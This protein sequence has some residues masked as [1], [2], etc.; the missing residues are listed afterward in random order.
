MA[1]E[2][3]LASGARRGVMVDAGPLDAGTEPFCRGIVNGERQVVPAEPDQQR[4][5]HEAEKACGDKGAAPS[6][7]PEQRI[8]AA[9]VNG[10]ASGT[11]PRGDRAT[12]L[13][14]ENSQK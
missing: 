4:L 9:E 8:R 7:R 6:H 1:I 14:Q 3:L 11:E 5:E 10:D 2:E 13:G 12:A